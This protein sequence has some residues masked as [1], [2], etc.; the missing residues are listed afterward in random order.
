MPRFF[1]E[2]DQIREDKIDIIGQDVRHIRDVLRLDCAAQIEVCDGQGTDYHCIIDEINK[3]VIIAK[4]ISKA[5]S[6][7]EP[8]TRLILFQSL[9]KGDKIEWVIQKATE[10]GVDK[11]VPMQTTY[12]VSKTDKSKKTDA[13]ISRW[14]KIANSAAKQSGRGIVPEVAMPV[15]FSQALNLCSDMDLALMAYEKENQRN[16]KSHIKGYEGKTIGILIGPEGG[17]S[18]EEVMQADK[19]GIG[20]ITLG[21]RIL[22]SETA[23]IALLSNILYELGEMDL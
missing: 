22:R 7:S 13:K 3:E 14:N 15:T 6:D 19:A 8:K 23:S 20:A 16:L 4:V 21:P 17:F 5:P 12:C 9:I 11:I 10:L 18:K 2:P 1:V